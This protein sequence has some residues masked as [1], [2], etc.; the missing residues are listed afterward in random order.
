MELGDPVAG[1]G[2]GQELAQTV[3]VEFG[4]VALGVFDLGEAAC[5]I[6]AVVGFS[7]R[8]L[9]SAE[10]TLGVVEVAD[11]G[12]K[13]ALGIGER[14]LGEAAFGVECLLD[15]IAVAVFQ[16][17]GPAGLVVVEGDL[18]AIGVGDGG[19]VADGIVFI[20]YQKQEEF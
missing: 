14:A 16:A 7:P 12:Q 9:T 6:V 17:G 10:P 18:F 8:A 1:L 5:L 20:L 19:E 3:V 2:D 11:G 15:S 13:L 4:G